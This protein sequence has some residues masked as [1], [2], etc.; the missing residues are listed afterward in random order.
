VSQTFG[1]ILALS[2]LGTRQID[3]NHMLQYKGLDLGLDLEVFAVNSKRT[4]LTNPNGMETLGVP[5]AFCN[6]LNIGV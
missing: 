2:D 4:H 3:H 5:E 1:L 6:F